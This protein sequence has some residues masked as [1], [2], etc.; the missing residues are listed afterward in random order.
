MARSAPTND[1]SPTGQLGRTSRSSCAI[2]V[3]IAAAWQ[4][5]GMGTRADQQWW[6]TAARIALACASA[7]ARPLG[8]VAHVTVQSGAT[9]TVCDLAEHEA[10]ASCSA[11]REQAFFA[12]FDLLL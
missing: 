7:F 11:G 3:P 1:L 10:S 8:G 6:G 2:A 4:S 12:A 9:T 5:L